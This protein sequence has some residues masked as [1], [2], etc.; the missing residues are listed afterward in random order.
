M[1]VRYIESLQLTIGDVISPLWT[2]RARHLGTRR[3]HRWGPP[4]PKI[5]TQ[6]LRLRE[7]LQRT[8]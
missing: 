4:M 2:E 6:V 8:Q 7:R 3:L 1:P 5:A